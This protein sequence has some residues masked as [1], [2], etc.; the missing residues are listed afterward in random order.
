MRNNAKQ[1]YRPS[2]VYM[3]TCTAESTIRLPITSSKVALPREQ[4][5]TPRSA[6]AI[7]SAHHDYQN[8]SENS[9][10]S[11]DD[12]K[13]VGINDAGSLLEIETHKSDTV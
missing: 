7:I 4:K 1:H 6:F 9:D 12:L 8:E 10:D 11:D 13:P 2:I 3:N 5:I